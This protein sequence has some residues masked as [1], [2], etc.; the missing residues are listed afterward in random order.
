MDGLSIVASIIA[1]CQ[2]TNEV[3]QYLNDAKEAPKEC[4]RCI[5]EAS[6]LLDLLIS[7][8]FHA[9]QAKIG[10]C[11][12]EQLRKL[13]VKDGPLDQYK[14]ALESLINKVE[15]KDGIQKVKGRL[16]WKFNKKQVAEILARV[17]R[18][19]SLVSI[20]LE[21]DHRQVWRNGRQV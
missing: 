4:Q 8:R 15:I 10:D 12:F 19:K 3:V 20:A 11:W 21:M 7:L 9:E 2:L 5:I 17:E 1:V 13:N 18:L 16:L 14:Q 6:N